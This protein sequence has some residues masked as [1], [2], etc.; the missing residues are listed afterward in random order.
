MNVSEK[1]SISYLDNKGKLV[2]EPYSILTTSQMNNIKW[3]ESIDKETKKVTYI[4]NR[5]AILKLWSIDQ[6]ASKDEFLNH[7]KDFNNKNV[8]NLIIDL[9][10]NQGGENDN[11]SYLYSFLL[12]KNSK[13]LNQWKY[14]IKACITRSRTPLTYFMVTMNYT[15]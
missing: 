13:H 7:F 8:E 1:L 5:T 9:R 14:V 6:A 2:R 10:G 11:L 4:N 12:L 3:P 15:H